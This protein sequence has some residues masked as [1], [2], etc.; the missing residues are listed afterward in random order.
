MNKNF[1]I[2]TIL[3]S[4]HDTKSNTR[5]FV[6]DFVEEMEKAGLAL[7]HEVIPL[8]RR[9]VKTCKG[10]WNCT[11]D[12]PCPLANDDLTDIKKSIVECDMLILASPV[13]TNQVTAQMKA[14]FD[15]LFTWCHIYPLLGKYSLSAVTSGNEGQKETGSFLEKM[16]ATYG[17]FSFGSILSIGGFTPGFFPWREQSRNK[18]RKLAKKVAKTILLEKR[19]KR[20]PIQRKIYRTMKK[21]MSGSHSINSMIHGVPDGQPTPPKRRLKIMRFFLNKMNVTEKQ[22]EEMAG[23]MSFEL[24][25]WRDRGWLWT[26][27][28]KQ[29]SAMPV[30]EDFNVRDRLIGS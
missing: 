25:W 13:Y 7:E 10:C 12:K 17:T 11:K 24:T 27:S 22:L 15:R 19:P 5:A 4:P 28:F 2:V 18:Y 30:P 20:R 8:G 6:E 3:G 23:L 14:F 9:N 29:L 21:K 26:K 1:K 16:L